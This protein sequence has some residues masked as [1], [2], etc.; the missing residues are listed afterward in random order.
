MKDMFL[1]LRTVIFAWAFLGAETTS[2]M[3]RPRAGCSMACYRLE[4]APIRKKGG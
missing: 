2:S 3:S 1:I 4:F